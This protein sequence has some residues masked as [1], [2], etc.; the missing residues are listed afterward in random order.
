MGL[1]ELYIEGDPPRIVT[2][3]RVFPGGSTIHG[4]PIQPNWTRV[5]VDQVEDA[6][7]QVSVPTIEVQQVGQALGTFLAWPRHLV[8]TPSSRTKVCNFLPYCILII[9]LLFN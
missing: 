2:F 6:T 7:A 1:C 3:G 5:M 8:M 4:V 9:V